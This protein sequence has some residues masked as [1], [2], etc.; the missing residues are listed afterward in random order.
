MPKCKR[1]SMRVFE[2]SEYHL[3][4]INLDVSKLFFVKTN[5]QILSSS[6]FLDHR[7]RL[8]A[9]T[10]YEQPLSHA[11][12]WLDSQVTAKPSINYLFHTAFCCSTLI[13][14]CLDVDGLNLSLK[15]PNVLMT[16]ANYKRHDRKTSRY[17]GSI[18]LALHLLSKTFSPGE[19]LLIKPTNAANNLL[20][21]IMGLP[22]TG[23]IVLLYSDLE[24]FLISVVKSG[25]KRRNFVRK[26]CCLI[27]HDDKGAHPIEFDQLAQLSDLQIASLVW[28]LQMKNFDRCLSKKNASVVSLNCSDML[29]HPFVALSKMFLHYG[30]K[31]EQEEIQQIV[32]QGAFTQDSKNRDTNYSH[33]NRFSDYKTIRKM[34]A[35]SLEEV[36]E[37]SELLGTNMKIPKQL[38]NNLMD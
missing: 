3:S 20:M 16:L 34:Y 28:H 30:L 27:A 12:N 23:S 24:S 13:A 37:W 6:A 10:Y 25:E 32:T 18:E 35:Q 38:P 9:P 2:E 15:E 29:M 4:N 31:I 5:R 14:R 33:K 11:K 1:E 22:S 19:S 7:L 21:D 36:L 26:L 17:R 8:T